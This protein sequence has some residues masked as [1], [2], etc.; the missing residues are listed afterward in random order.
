[1]HTFNPD[2]QPVNTHVSLEPLRLKYG[3]EPLQFGDL[4]LPGS[5]GPRPIVI[6]I[7]GGY[8]RA[9]YGLDLMNS[10]A[11][12]LAQRGY[13]AW[14]I[15]YRRVGDPGGGWP[16]TFLDVALAT[17][18]L[19]KLA[20]T[21]A[22][23]LQQVIS[24]GHSAGGHLAFWVAARPRIPLFALNSPLRGSQ[25]PNHKEE[26]ATPLILAWA[27]SLAG[28]VDL[29]MAWRLNLSNGA[30]VELLGGSITDVP[31]RYAAASPAAMLPLGVPQVLIHGTLDENVPLQLSQSYAKAARAVNDPVTY[32]ELEG[33]DHFDVIDPHS[34]AW[35]IT[36]EEL[37]KLERTN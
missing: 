7:H 34:N 11:E 8:W 5:P 10:L 4:Y 20:P 14:N 12:D 3:P 28:V 31:E 2:E 29:A 21:Y 15:E 22:L 33:I 23:D 16:G 26:T 24:I 6:L 32:I 18:Y 36:I 27:I 17:D 35:A 1:M 13:A 19:R 25:Q 30:V 9:R 37:Q